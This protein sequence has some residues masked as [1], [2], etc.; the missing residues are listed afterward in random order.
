MY[1]DVVNM[2]I[3]YLYFLFESTYYNNGFD[4]MYRLKFTCVFYAA[5]SQP[6]EIHKFIEPKK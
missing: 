6:N 3:V 5:F 2:Y 4:W 1:A